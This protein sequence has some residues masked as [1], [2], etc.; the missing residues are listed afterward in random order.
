M[1]VAAVV[2]GLGLLSYLVGRMR[3]LDRIAELGRGVLWLGGCA[4]G[5]ALLSQVGGCAAAARAVRADDMRP[6]VRQAVAVA[7]DAA[8]AARDGFTAWDRAHQMRIA[9]SMPDAAAK[10]VEYR[11]RR[12][13]VVAAFE[14]V[15]RAIETAAAL[16]RV[17]DDPK[18]LEDLQRSLVDAFGRLA[19]ARAIFAS[20]AATAAP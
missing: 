15:Y 17:L 9:T 1:I 6:A 7:L 19:A 16:A 4:A 18:S 14:A 13:P 12:A 10:L 2:I 5:V 20:M 11:A 8:D 3:H